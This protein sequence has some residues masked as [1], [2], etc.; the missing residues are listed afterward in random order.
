MWWSRLLAVML[1]SGCGLSPLYLS[2]PTPTGHVTLH[3]D[4]RAESL[5]FEDAWIHQNIL[6]LRT[7]KDLILEVTTSSE[8]RDSLL[9]RTA[10]I[11][12]RDYTLRVTYVLKDQERQ[13]T[14]G[15]V[16]ESTS[17]NQVASPYAN[18]Q[19]QHSARHRAAKAAARSV[20]NHLT[21]FLNTRNGQDQTPG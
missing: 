14:Q 17:Y 2:G 19:S 10:R 18:L 20:Y 12:R 16:Q 1:V 7:N 5:L 9:L 3:H 6:R 21:T 8:D 4:G 11:T 15:A 13:L